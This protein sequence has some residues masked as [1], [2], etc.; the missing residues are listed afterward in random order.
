MTEAPAGGGGRARVERSIIEK[1]L[2]DN[3]FRQR[4]LADPKAALEEEIGA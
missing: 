2:A 3:S 1:S 4:L